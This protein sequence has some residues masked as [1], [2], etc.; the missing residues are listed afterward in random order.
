MWRGRRFHQSNKTD[1]GCQW[2]CGAKDRISSV[3]QPYVL[4]Y[5]EHFP[6]KRGVLLDLEAECRVIRQEVGRDLALI[7]DASDKL[8]LGDI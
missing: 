2:L 5:I 4:S 8:S 1:G 3:V 6:L 7:V